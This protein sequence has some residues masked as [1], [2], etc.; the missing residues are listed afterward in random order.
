MQNQTDNSGGIKFGGVL[1]IALLVLKLTGYIDWSW[2]WITAVLWFPFLFG[3]ILLIIYL[4]IK[5]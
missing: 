5:K 4:T 2:W 1:F 3:V